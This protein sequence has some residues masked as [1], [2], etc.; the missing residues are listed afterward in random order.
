MSA[1]DYAWLKEEMVDN[2]AYP[3]ALVVWL[4]NPFDTSVDITDAG[5]VNDTRLEA[6]YKKA[7]RDFQGIEGAGEP[8]DKYYHDQKA[9]IE[10][11]IG[12]LWELNPA[13][14]AEH[15]NKGIT[16]ARNSAERKVMG[17]LPTTDE[18]KAKSVATIEANLPQFPKRK[19]SDDSTFS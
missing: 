10:L 14:Q 9:V 4:T 11:T 17:Q 5:D 1:I 8:D 6:C 3:L 7:L 13:K 16:A 18:A 2:Q 12:Y 19:Q 15:W